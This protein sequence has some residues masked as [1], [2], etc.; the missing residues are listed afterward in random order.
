VKKPRNKKYRPREIQTDPVTWA[1]AGVHKFPTETIAA[2]FV[3]V[4]EAMLLLKLGKATREDWNVPCQS[5]NIA[6][7]LAGLRI[8]PNLMPQIRAGQEAL[9]KIAQR[10]IGTGKA[11]C[12]GAELA[13]IDEALVMYR[14][15]MKVCT[16]G[17]FTRA[18]NRVKELH[19]SGGMDDMCR[20]YD[21]MTDHEQ[22]KAA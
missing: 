2:T 12:Y 19:R 11:T 9:S 18:V 20:L 15:Q 10:M 13:A 1:I 17:E 4:D 3:P 8:G 6:E 7:A 21:R 16:Q 22:M 5:L 14:V